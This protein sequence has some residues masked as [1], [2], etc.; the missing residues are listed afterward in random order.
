MVLDAPHEIEGTEFQTRMIQENN[1]G[2]LLKCHM[3][4][5]DGKAVFFYEITGMQPIFKIYEKALMTQEDIENL[6]IGVKD[7][8]QNTERYLLNGNELLFEPEYL[9]MDVQ[10]REFYMCYL[11]FYDGDM[12]KGFRGLTEYILK[13]LDHS[14][15]E[16]LMLGY[17]VYS[18]AAEENYRISDAI[19][20]M[21]QYRKK[22]NT[23]CTESEAEE[24]C[25]GEYLEEEC[26]EET[27]DRKMQEVSDE[28]HEEKSRIIPKKK[29]Y[30]KWSIL[31][32]GL[33]AFWGIGVVLIVLNVLSIAQ[34]GGVLFLVTTGILYIG[35]GASQGK[36]VS[37]K[38][39]S[40]EKGFKRMDKDNY[41]EDVTCILKEDKRQGRAVLVSQKPKQYEDFVL[42]KLETHVG[43]EERSADVCIPCSVVSRAHAKIVKN[44]ESYY[45]TDLAS[46]N[47]TYINGKRIPPNEA[48]RLESGDVIAFASVEYV[49]QEKDP[50]MN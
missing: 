21:F 3:R 50:L 44:G 6:L 4:M 5:I 27:Y 18:R 30:K 35:A 24:E 28:R 49:F 23:Q 10:T 1:I 38:A 39:G 26:L 8:L 32:L 12:T 17:A 47:G 33:A 46:T 31:V 29:K 9:F 45:V 25:C 16:A 15:E 42:C 37:E 36:A 13:K 41:E 19:Q 34:A 48:M 14:D 40:R 43:K 22:E 2:H 11:P 20:S 7:V